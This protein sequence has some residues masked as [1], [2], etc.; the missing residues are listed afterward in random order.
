MP[1]SMTTAANTGVSAERPCPTTAATSAMTTLRRCDRRYG[2]R[3]RIH[4]PSGG[5]VT[6]LASLTRWRLTTEAGCA[7]RIRA[8]PAPRRPRLAPGTAKAPPGEPDGAF[9]PRRVGS[10]D[11]DVLGLVAL[12]TRGDVELDV[13]ALFEVLVAAA[14]DV[15]VVHEDVVAPVT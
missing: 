7:S 11:P 1:S 5:F 2:L 4:P 6:S 9:E 3:R 10:D 13:L 12:A 14:G 8:G 15:G